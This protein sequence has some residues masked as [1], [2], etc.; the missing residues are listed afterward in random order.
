MT[1]TPQPTMTSVITKRL[2]SSGTSICHFIAER[3]LTSWGAESSVAVALPHFGQNRAF[4]LREAP[5]WVQK[6]GLG[7][8]LKTA[9][10]RWSLPEKAGDYNVLHVERMVWPTSGAISR[11]IRKSY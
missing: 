9:V 7:M 8:V 3:L 6:A 11:M 1:V 4:S 2:V 5:H 10:D